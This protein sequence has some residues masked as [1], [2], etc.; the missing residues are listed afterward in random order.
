MQPE[1]QRRD[2]IVDAAQRQQHDHDRIGQALGAKALP[3][4]EACNH[5][6]DRPTGQHEVEEEGEQPRPHREHVEAEQHEGQQ[7]HRQR[8]DHEPDQ[9]HQHQ[10]GGELERLQRAHH[11]VGE[12]ARPD[13][14]QKGEGEAEL[15][16]KQ[17]VPEQDGAE[18]QAGGGGHRRLAVIEVGV[19]ETPH[20]HLHRRPVDDLEQPEP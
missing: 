14:L 6:P 4:H 2:R 13:L 5:E 7:H 19:E 16:A 9:A 18:Q 20:Q 11:Q 8:A 10:R 3:D 17:H 15:A 1:R 12:V